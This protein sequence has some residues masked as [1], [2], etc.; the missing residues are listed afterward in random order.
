MLDP[1][2]AGRDILSG[3]HANTQFPKLIGLARLYEESG[4]ERHARAAR[5]FRDTVARHHSYVI[6]GNSEREHFGPADTFASRLNDRTCEACNSYNM[7]KLTRHVYGWAPDAALFD[8]YERIHLNHILAH[9]HPETGMFA[10]FMPLAAGARRTWSTPDNSFWCCVGSGMESHAKHGDSIYWQDEATLY[11]NLFI[12]SALDWRGLKLELDTDFPFDETVTLTLSEASDAPVDIA[13]RLP[14]WCAAPEV[15]L[16][17]AA[18][19]IERRDNYA[20]LR[21]RWRRGDRIELHL[22]M[23]LRIEPTP[24]DPNVVAYLSGPLVLAA[25]L[26]EAATPFE[27]LAP[28]LVDSGAPQTPVAVDRAAHRYRLRARPADVPLL[29]FFSQ[30]DRRTAVYFPKVTEARWS[31]LEAA[32]AVEQAARTALDARTVD[33]IL[34]GEPDSETAHGFSTNHSDP[35]AWGGRSGRQAWWGTGNF[36]AFDLAVRPGPMVLQALYWGEEVGKHFAILVGGREIAVERR[37]APPVQRFVTQDYP[38]PAD[39]IAG[40]SS[41]TV[42]IETRG[43]DAPVYE[44]RTLAPSPATRM[45]H[46]LDAARRTG[47]HRG[48]RPA[49]LAGAR[50]AAARFPRAGADAADGVEQLGQ[51]RSDDQR[52]AGPRQCRDDG[53]EAAAARL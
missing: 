2:A 51:L 48:G 27:R 1:I 3:L 16:N 13:L 33:R 18:V 17:G 53:R 41:V 34:L 4:D 12:P 5:F 40:R 30:Y 44:C 38:I 10:Y 23:A 25:D 9:Q 20:L 22:P 42:R 49:A 31:E 29:P 32:H 14:G 11:V 7:L 47:R 24:D 45:T 37:D 8:D 15:R 50:A 39:L 21:R 28:A 43:S 26:G 19:A 46:L 35:L 6:G 36:I 52:G